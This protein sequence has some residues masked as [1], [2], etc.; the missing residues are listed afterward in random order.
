[1]KYSALIIEDEKKSQRLLSQI[2]SKYCPNVDLIGISSKKLESINQ[3]LE[4]K[5]DVVFMDIDLEDCN[6]FEI[7]EEID[8]LKFKI[9]FT[10]AHEKYALKAFKV[11]A[12]DYLL[13]PYAPK[14]VIAA[15]ARLEKQDYSQEI[16]S[17]FKKMV[18]SN[19]NNHQNYQLSLNTV[20]GIY[21]VGLGD[22]IRIKA[23]GSYS[24]IYLINESCKVV[25]KNLLEIEKVVNHSDFFRVHTSHLVNMKK[26]K[27]FIK[28]DGGYLIMRDNS[29]VPVSR[30]NK[31]ELLKRLTSHN[32]HT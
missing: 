23:D 19:A 20:E 17:H 8:H 32:G 4:I 21:M 26:I 1:M 7:L 18:N 30:R 15:L 6:A 31:A 3:I 22:I 16:M 27:A 10:T 5:P 14:D 24:N 13:K 2:L 29:K 11:N 12:V 9:I 25:S 28:E